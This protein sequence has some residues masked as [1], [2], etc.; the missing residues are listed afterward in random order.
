VAVRGVCSSAPTNGISVKRFAGAISHVAR[1]V[2]EEFD[3]LFEPARTPRSA[4]EQPSEYLPSRFPTAVAFLIALVSIIA[5]V[6][7]WRAAEAGHEAAVLD[8]QAVQYLIQERA[9][10]AEISAEIDHDLRLDGSFV[11]HARAWSI[12]RRRA[13]RLARSGQMVNAQKA[14][15]RAQLEG[16]LARSLQPFFFLEKLDTVDPI[17]DPK[18]ARDIAFA[19][20]DYLRSP[21]SSA[22][23]EAAGRAHD[24]SLSLVLIEALVLASLFF[25]TLARFTRRRYSYALALLGSL[26]VGAGVVLWLLADLGAV[27]ALPTAVVGR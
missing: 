23:R 14:D 27:D 26:V 6:V 15:L 12:L 1:R 9:D 10:A 20:D 18:F 22:T 3:L 21:R 16:E 7:A 11:A 8:R 13:D 5:A 25:L 2:R 4:V 17:Y 24:R 19:A